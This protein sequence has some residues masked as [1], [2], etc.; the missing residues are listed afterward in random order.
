MTSEEFRKNPLVLRNHFDGQGIFQLPLVKKSN[1]DLSNIQLL[2]YDK[3][4]NNQY[5]KIVHFFLDD[6]KFEA[7][8]NNPD[9]RIE[10]LSK[11]KAVISP[12]FSIY[13]DMPMSMKVYQTF[14]NRWCG[15]YL[16]SKGI[17]VIP[18]LAWGEPDTYWFCFD[19]IEKGSIVAV[20]TIGV[21]K[22]KELFLNGYYEMLRKINPSAII[23][24]GE[25][26]DEMKGNIIAVDY[27]STNNLKPSKAYFVHKTYF[28][29]G[30]MN[31]GIGGGSG[32]TG[33]ANI[34]GFPENVRTSY[35]KYQDSGWKG[36]YNGQTPG[37]KAGRK[38]ENNPPK[39]PVK[40][41]NGNKLSYREFD[42]N[43][44]LPGQT[45]D[46]ERFVVDNNGRVYYSSD[47][48]NTFI[49]ITGD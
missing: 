29:D 18:S 47:H 28:F 35:G 15:A 40:D 39:L 2:G 45:R 8:W 16:Q 4:S 42:V 43:N 20:S 21:R 12:Q 49:E 14:R 32:S 33:S 30:I 38:F 23:C 9:D 27:A 37:T 31:K 26:F 5:E 41:E 6:Y 36:N 22:E 44:K 24:Y 11:Y 7:I 13:S 1:V 46:S 34:S 19:G 48:Y 3:L 25:T 10:R 17:K